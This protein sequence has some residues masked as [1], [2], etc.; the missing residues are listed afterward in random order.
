M[1]PTSEQM[2]EIKEFTALSEPSLEEL[3]A[4]ARKEREAKEEAV[5]QK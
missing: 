5:R 1:W 3:L 2:A 4:A